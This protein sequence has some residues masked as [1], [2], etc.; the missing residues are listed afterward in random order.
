MIRSKTVWLLLALLFLSVL[1]TRQQFDE[2][3]FEDE[4]IEDTHHEFLNGPIIVLLNDEEPLQANV[5]RDFDLRYSIDSLSDITH[6]EWILNEDYHSKQEAKRFFETVYIQEGHKLE[7][8]AH[9]GLAEKD[10]H[11]VLRVRNKLGLEA[12][13]EFIVSLKDHPDLLTA[14][15]DP[16]RGE[17]IMQTFRV[18]LTKTSKVRLH[19][20][21][22]Y[23]MGKRKSPVH[24]YADV[25]PEDEEV[26]PIVPIRFP[27]ARD[28]SEPATIRIDYHDDKGISNDILLSVIIER[29]TIFDINTIRSLLATANER[30]E[31]VIQSDLMTIAQSILRI[32]FL[33]ELDHGHSISHTKS[34][35]DTFCN[36]HGTCSPVRGTPYKTCACRGEW[37]GPTCSFEPVKQHEVVD[38]LTQ[39]AQLLTKVPFEPH[40]IGYAAETLKAISFSRHIYDAGLFSEIRAAFSRIV[41][42]LNETVT[43]FSIVENLLAVGEHVI[44]AESSNYFSRKDVKP[45]LPFTHIAAISDDLERLMVNIA[46]H[47]TSSDSQNVKLSMPGI[48]FSLKRISKQAVQV[49]EELV[50]ERGSHLTNEMKTMIIRLQRSV[51][52][53]LV[54]HGDTLSLHTYMT[55]HNPY[56][57]VS[58]IRHNVVSDVV[59]LLIHDLTAPNLP[60]IYL[61]QTKGQVIVT[62]QKPERK[63]DLDFVK[64]AVW[65]WDYDSFVPDHCTTSRPNGASFVCLCNKLGS[66]ALITV[67]ENG[68]GLKKKEKIRPNIVPEFQFHTYTS[69]LV[70]ALAIVAALWV[71]SF[72]FSRRDDTTNGPFKSAY[73][74]LPL[75]SILF[76][77]KSTLTRIIRLHLFVTTIAV[78]FLLSAGFVTVYGG[79]HDALNVLSVLVIS[80]IL[81]YVWGF[82]ARFFA[83]GEQKVRG[84]TIAVAFLNI[85]IITC[86]ILGAFQAGLYQDMGAGRLY[87]LWT[88]VLF[89][90]LAI[91]DP[92]TVILGRGAKLSGIFR[93]RGFY[94]DDQVPL[95]SVQAK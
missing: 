84:R 90:D 86:F 38:A 55:R 56:E 22:S 75:Y 76:V 52:A 11:L 25:S 35:D 49:Q 19:Y 44:I 91:A 9:S 80:S 65:D 82:L 12:S 83:A 53:D 29:A 36:G 93:F 94:T 69:H 85:I 32:Y 77:P 54:N 70:T 15:V 33:E 26:L 73:T 89:I 8:P 43:D 57:V 7:I 37:V 63:T 1:P 18:T 27:V 95:Q 67:K 10:Y 66:Y 24:V 40:T 88:F 78:Q 48:G 4:S 30:P 23:T 74:T 46:Y 5:K 28:L 51:L 45:D 20:S 14:V 2:E 64:C 21:V 41:S 60:S 61:N 13:R 72:I 62:F 47:R 59:T 87:E 68:P 58:L 34:C 16:E 79:G 3:G 31:N 71:L 42:S 6:E 81:N 17:G 50:V 92:I 39:I